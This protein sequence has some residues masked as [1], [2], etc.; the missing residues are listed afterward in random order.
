[1]IPLGWIGVVS[2]VLLRIVIPLWF[3]TFLAWMAVEAY[4]WYLLFEFKRGNVSA[5]ELPPLRSEL[6]DDS[7]VDLLRQ[8]R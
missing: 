7:L 2:D 4:Q 3:V 5:D 6:P 8:L 1:M